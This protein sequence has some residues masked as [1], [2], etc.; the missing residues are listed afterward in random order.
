MAR[1]VGFTYRKKPMGRHK[2]IH[3]RNH[4]KSQRR[5]LSRGQG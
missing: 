4:S 2:G 5:K 1:S 3:S